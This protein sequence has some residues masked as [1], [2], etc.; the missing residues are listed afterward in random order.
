MT[1]LHSNELFLSGYFM[2]YW[3]MKTEPEVLS[4]KD[5]KEK[6]NQCWDGVRNYQA[7][8]YMMKEMKLNDQIFFYHS[9]ANPSGIVGLAR[10]SKLAYPDHTQ[11]DPKSEYYDPKASKEKPRWFMVEIAYVDSFKKIITLD[12]LRKH[13]ILSEMVVLK[14]GNRLSIT[15]VKKIEFDYIL[16]IKD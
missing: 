16:K 4:I 1:K 12:D 7:R 5:L 6:K 10:V 14:K 13:K 2:N 11:F 9:N 15:P 8:N 3:L